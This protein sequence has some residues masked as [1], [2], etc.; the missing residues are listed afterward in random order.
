MRRTKLAKNISGDAKLISSAAGN[1]THPRPESNSTRNIQKLS[2]DEK[3]YEGENVPDGFYDSILSLKKVDEQTLSLSDSF[4]SA[5]ETYKC[6]LKICNSG[7]K[8]PH[9]SL[10]KAEEI[11]KLKS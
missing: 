1:H 9:I 5:S 3:V 4:I 11:L 7:S 8:V 6:I 10:K 2:V